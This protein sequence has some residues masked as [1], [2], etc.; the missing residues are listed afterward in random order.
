MFF[1]IYLIRMHSIKNTTSI[2]L[3]YKNTSTRRVSNEMKYEY[4]GKNNQPNLVL[5]DGI[6]QS[7]Y[8]SNNIV[9]Q[10]NELQIH[11]TS[12][13]NY[14]KKAIV[15]I[16]LA[17]SAMEP[18]NGI[19]YIIQSKY[20]EV[21]DINLNKIIKNFSVEINDSQ[22]N[23][24]VIRLK[25]PVF[26]N[27]DLTIQDTSVE[28]FK[29]GS[30]GMSKNQK[31]RLTTLETGLANV[32][33][34]ASQNSYG[35]THLTKKQIADLNSLI[36]GDT[37]SNLIEV[38]DTTTQ[39]GMKEMEC[40]P[41]EGEVWNKMFVIDGYEPKGEMVTDSSIIGKAKNAIDIKNAINKE[42]KQLKEAIEKLGGI[43]TDDSSKNI[44]F[45]IKIESKDDND[46]KTVRIHDEN[47]KPI[48]AIRKPSQ[49][50]EAILIAYTS[51]E[52]TMNAKA[53]RRDK[54]SEVN[55]Y[56][57]VAIP[58]YITHEQ[59]K[60]ILALMYFVI[61]GFGSVISFYTI[62]EFYKIFIRRLTKDVK[63]CRIDGDGIMEYITGF[64]LWFNII[65]FLLPAIS[66]LASGGVNGTQGLMSIWMIVT[67]TMYAKW[68]IQ[69]GFF[70][71]FYPREGFTYCKSAPWADSII[72]IGSIIS[73][74]IYG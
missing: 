32:E 27:T 71:S 36:S 59:N 25:N 64:K 73:R 14:P 3:N 11:H 65:F 40:F 24:Y 2:E 56:T 74:I 48:D 8:T 62:P 20:N 5:L 26:I 72:K 4:H 34:H 42:V 49:A 57:H 47:G 46:I 28:G 53:F 16:P 37:I 67:A 10:N 22:K 6:K 21:I 31:D 12:S 9:I 7:A 23:T 33:K 60:S 41:N 1:C 18:K 50:R 55:E 54:L 30:C 15:I 70:S 19:D 29:E 35:F 45:R 68:K 44:D 69:P 61:L 63:S 52:V 13:S 38:G 51:P 17:T 39:N 66:M 43:Y 58:G